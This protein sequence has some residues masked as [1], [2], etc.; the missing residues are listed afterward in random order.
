[1]QAV[2]E[3]LLDINDAKKLLAGTVAE[4][5]A[6]LSSRDKKAIQAFI[7]ASGLQ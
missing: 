2:H 4:A 7:K 3:G 6:V 1:M 5:Q